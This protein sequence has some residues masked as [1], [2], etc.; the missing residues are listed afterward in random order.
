MRY[1]RPERRERATL[2]RVRV[3]NRE[4]NLEAGSA[5]GRDGGPYGRTWG[6]SADENG[7]EVD[8]LLPRRAKNTGDCAG[9]MFAL[10]PPRSSLV[11]GR[12]AR[13]CYGLG[14]NNLEFASWIRDTR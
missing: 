10:P 6:G 1:D 9:D 8:E 11:G 5:A 4:M 13:S 2:G 14:T 12:R 7:R 3:R